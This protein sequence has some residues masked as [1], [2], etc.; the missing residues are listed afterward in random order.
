MGALPCVLG[1][2][3]QPACGLQRRSGPLQ[4][5]GAVGQSGGQ[6]FQVLQLPLQDRQA[7][8]QLGPQDPVAHLLHVAQVGVGG[9]SGVRGDFSCL[10]NKET[11]P[12]RND[13]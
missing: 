5:A 1:L 8:G 2:L 4:D 12:L 7:Q 13:Q 9:C 10:L 6:G 3:Q 11:S